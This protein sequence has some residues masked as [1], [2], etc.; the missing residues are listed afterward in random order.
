VKVTKQARAK[1]PRGRQAANLG[2]G[3]L[4][5]ELLLVRPPTP[6]RYGEASAACGLSD[7][8]HQLRLQIDGVQLHRAHAAGA[9]E[10]RPRARGSRR[11]VRWGTRLRNPAFRLPLPSAQGGIRTRHEVSVNVSQGA[12]TPESLDF[13]AKRRSAK[14]A[15]ASATVTAVTAPEDPSGYLRFAEQEGLTVEDPPPEDDDPGN[16]V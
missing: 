10:R 15:D 1:A 4:A 9:P 12:Q 16:E 5:P 3:L 2:S 6:R 14:R 7:G 13:G 11:G 8:L